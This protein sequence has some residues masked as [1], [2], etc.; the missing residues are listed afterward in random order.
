V[1]D[2][3]ARNGALLPMVAAT[4]KHS[5]YDAIWLL[6]VF[7]V[8]AFLLAAVPAT[9]LVFTGLTEDQPIPSFFGEDRLFPYAWMVAIGL[10]FALATLIASIA[11]LKHRHHFLSFLYLYLPIAVC[12]ISA[13]GWGLTFLVDSP[14]FG[15]VR[16]IAAALPIVGMAPVLVSPLFQPSIWVLVAHA[17]LTLGLIWLFLKRNAHWF[18]AHLEEL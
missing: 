5:F 14:A 9:L 7:R 3:F 6:T 13:V 8:G 12:A 1:L 10:S 2:Y 18:A 17:L 11:D 15:Y 4:G 16:N